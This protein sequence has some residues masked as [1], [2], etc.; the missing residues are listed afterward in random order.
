VDE[1]MRDLL[2]RTRAPSGM[3]GKDMAGWE[4]R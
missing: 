3:D 1:I 4:G 2:G